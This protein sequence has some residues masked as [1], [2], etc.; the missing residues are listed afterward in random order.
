[1]WVSTV[2]V[3]DFMDMTKRPVFI[4]LTLFI[5]MLGISYFYSEFEPAYALTYFDRFMVYLLAPMIIIYTSLRKDYIEYVL[6]AFILAMFINEVISYG[7]L[8]GWWLDLEDGYPIYF[9]HHVFYSILLSFTIMLLVYK[10]VHTTHNALKIIAFIFLMTMIGN[11]IISGGRS[12]QVVL[13]I[14]FI[15]TML[16]FY[17]TT[18]RTIGMSI[19]SPILIFI[20]AYN[21]YPQFQKRADM[22]VTDTYK[23]VKNK[24]YNTS[25]GTR[26]AGYVLTAKMIEEATVMELLFG[27]GVG[28]LNTVKKEVIKKH[29]ENTMTDQYKSLHFH[30]SYLDTF[31]RLGF[32]GL[33]FLIMYLTAIYRLKIKDDQ[34]KYIKIAL[35]FILLISY[36]P[37][38]SLD[39]QY[40]MLMTAI[41]LGILLVREKHERL[42]G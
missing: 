3:N 13:V 21:T 38:T 39:A 35:F 11:L 6:N 1:L 31:G 17:K 22:V 28:D 33:M 34:M 19:L 25:F 5:A 23:A 15:M 24:D 2:K 4:W 7:I 10:F 18:I 16:I 41:F 8:F 32:V 42:R 36:F 27:Y 30:C 20:L 14:S 12:G 29:F 40:I 9:M 37:D 26:L